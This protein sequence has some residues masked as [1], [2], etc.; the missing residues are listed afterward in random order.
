MHDQIIFTSS[1]GLDNL[2]NSLTI[3]QQFAWLNL[4]EMHNLKKHICA[5]SFFFSTYIYALFHSI[6]YNE[7][8]RDVDHVCVVNEHGVE[9][10]KNGIDRN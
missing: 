8:F 9:K 1:S 5:K 10:F 6:D 3:N 7:V 2:F 4:H